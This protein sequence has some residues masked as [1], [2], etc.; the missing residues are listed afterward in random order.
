M[1]IPIKPSSSVIVI[2][3][4]IINCKSGYKNYHW[5]HKTRAE[6]YQISKVVQDA[7][8]RGGRIRTASERRAVSRGDHL[9][10]L[11]LQ[12]S[13]A[14]EASRGSAANSQAVLLPAVLPSATPR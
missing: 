4:V 10:D 7:Y 1:C 8:V 11:S 3:L 2:V 6:I 14:A 13:S 9:R 5:P 12:T